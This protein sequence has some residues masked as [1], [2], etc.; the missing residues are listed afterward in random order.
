[1]RLVVETPAVVEIAA[2]DVVATSVLGCSAR[3]TSRIVD[4]AEGDRRGRGGCRQQPDDLPQPTH[5]SPKV[6]GVIRRL[7]DT[8]EETLL[9]RSVALPAL[10]MPAA[11]W[12]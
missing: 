3:R 2:A 9:R 4:Q 6:Q 10:A 5:R 11:L 12:A 7:T 1:M 8:V